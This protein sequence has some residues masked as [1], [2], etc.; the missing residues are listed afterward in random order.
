MEVYVCPHHWEKDC[1]CRKPKP[2]LFYQASRDWSL[3]L[4]KTIYIGDDTRDCEA[5]YNAGCQ[6]IFIGTSKELLK[7]KSEE[8]PVAHAEK[9]S[10]VLPVIINHYS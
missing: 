4:D 5:A 3:R 6:S 1:Y 7:L 2:G 9:L 10:D 8:M